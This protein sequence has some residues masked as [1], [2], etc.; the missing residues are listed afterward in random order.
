MVDFNEQPIDGHTKLARVHSVMNLLAVARPI[1][2]SL[3][4]SVMAELI[5]EASETDL[6]DEVGGLERTGLVEKPELYNYGAD[7][8]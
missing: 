5:S 7:F 6:P 3:G 4:W 2:G 1:I 8:E